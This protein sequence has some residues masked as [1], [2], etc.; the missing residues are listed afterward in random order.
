MRIFRRIFGPS[1]RFVQLRET[2]GR[3]EGMRKRGGEGEKR[4]LG[5]KGGIQVAG[6][7]SGGEAGRVNLPWEKMRTP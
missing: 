6:E 7:E 3:E 5:R 2:G 1:F 4:R